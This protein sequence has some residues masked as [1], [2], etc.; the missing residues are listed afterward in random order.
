MIASHN[1]PMAE[2]EPMVENESRTDRSGFM[3]LPSLPI[4]A[5]KVKAGNLGEPVLV[6]YLNLYAEIE[7]IHF[8]GKPHSL[9]SLR[10]QFKIKPT[11]GEWGWMK[12]SGH[13]MNNLKGLVSIQEDD[14]ILIQRHS[15]PNENEIV[16][17]F[18]VETNTNDAY[19]FVK[20][21]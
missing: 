8:E 12:V 2:S 21:I 13:S 14:Y 11:T 1:E 10:S 5:Q 16:V 4:Y 9:H 20:R 7:Q 18:R 3:V 17:A 6:Q 19:L 15:N